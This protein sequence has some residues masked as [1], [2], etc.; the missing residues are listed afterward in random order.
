MTDPAPSYQAES[1]RYWREVIVARV[2][3][4]AEREHTLVGRA[5]L[6]TRFERLDGGIVEFR[7][8]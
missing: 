2:A 1:D 7:H 5:D 3:A 8:S 6:V 4:R